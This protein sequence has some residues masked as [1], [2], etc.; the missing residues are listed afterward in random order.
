LIGGF[1][2][3]I[4]SARKVS[5][6][7]VL[8]L[9]AIGFGAARALAADITSAQSGIWTNPST[10]TPAHVPLISDPVIITSGCTVT[11][12]DSDTHYAASLT[13]QD[14][15]VL[16]HASNSTTAA[17]E[18]YKVIL[19]I[20]NDL[21]IQSGGQ[22]NVD[23]RGYSGQNGP[24]Y[25][26]AGGASHGGVGAG[27]NAMATVATT[28]GS[29]TAPTRLGSGGS[30]N[31]TFQSGGGAVQLIVGGTATVNG[32]ISAAGV[33]TGSGAT[34]GG[35]SGG[36]VFLK[37]GALAGMGTIAANAASVSA[38]GLGGGGR[39][40]VILTGSTDFG[41]VKMQAYTG[42][43]GGNPG[44]GGTVYLEHTG[45]AAGEGTL[46][47]D[48]NKRLPGPD[49]R[50]ITLQ[51]GRDASAYA[52]SEIILTNGGVYGLDTNDTLTVAGLTAIRGDPAAETD[53]LYLQGG[54]LNAPSPFS[55]FSNYFIGI[56]APNATF[57][58]PL[59]LAVGTQASFIVNAPFVLPCPLTITPGGN[60]THL[61]NYT[62]EAYRVDLTVKGD[63]DIQA[64]GQVNVDGRGY[65]DG[66]G[67]GKAATYAS[68]GGSHGGAGGIRYA[69]T[70]TNGPTYGSITAPTTLGSGGGYGGAFG[71]GAARLNVTGRTTVNGVISAN[72][73]NQMM[74][75]A[76]GSVFLTTGTLDGSG[77]IRA[78]SPKGGWALGG[79][80]RVAVI[81]TNGNDFGSVSVQ[82]CSGLGNPATHLYGGAGTVY[83]QTMAQGAGNGTLWVNATNM[84]N[85][86][87]TVIGSQVTGTTVGTLVI[88]NG[89]V[90][91][92]DSNQSL[93]VQGNWLN[94]S[95]PVNGSL[96]NWTVSFTSAPN[97]TVT[98][99]GT[100]AAVVAGAT[101]FNN[102]TCTNRGKTVRFTAGTTNVVTGRLALGSE[103]T[104]GQSGVSLLSTAEGA[105]WYLTL[106]ASAPQQAGAVTVKDSQAGGGQTLRAGN[107]SINLEHNVNWTFPSA[108]T[109]VIMR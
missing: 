58:P 100:N 61:T 23:G 38:R 26:A 30:Y 34:Y 22:I 99:A 15:G 43:A 92:I 87:A 85:A 14:G 81:L 20:A 51:N 32:A 98:L 62:T 53:G 107:G 60:L 18:R 65:Q 6:R 46:I 12:Q 17:G 4:V 24:G 31:T 3:G 74:S 8:V 78:S 82:A 108:G 13:I 105:Y 5:R 84:L 42:A 76:G 39:V 83:L 103:M 104:P 68:T 49:P 33:E 21:T 67:P 93:T 94:L 89:A 80:G 69:T 66:Q 1:Q 63:L 41:A 79:G 7:L 25:L 91:M 88:T 35:S 9:L 56:S 11:I 97:S 96:T 52:F 77:I 102:L 64:G 50:F 86:H 57:D 95:K 27:V 55:T 71:G 47:V 48:Y 72:A 75:G 54:T 73:N 37:T 10:W 90:L 2:E 29:V 36:S 28:Y 40:A 45:H 44:A 19:A 106:A 101:T 16:T 70:C 59:S 109:T